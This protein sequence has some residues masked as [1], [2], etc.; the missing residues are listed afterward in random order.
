M[1]T[2]FEEYKKLYRREEENAEER[3]KKLCLIFGTIAFYYK[4]NSISLQAI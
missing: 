2:I 1:S 3:T 4:T